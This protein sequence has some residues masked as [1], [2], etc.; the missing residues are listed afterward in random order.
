MLDP[1]IRAVLTSP[2][3]IRRFF[4]TFGGVLI[5]LLVLL[6]LVAGLS[7]GALKSAAVTFLGNFAATMAILIV[8][9]G[10]Y[11]SVTPPGLRNAEVIPLRNVEI[12]E[13]IIDLRAN[14][15]DYWF[16]GR[17]GNHFRTT[18]LPVLDKA[19]RHERRHIRLRIV[20]PDPD[21]DANAH[22][23]MHM[24][25]GLGE[26]ADLDTLSAHV[27]ATIVA[28]ATACS[29]NPY[30]RAD[31]GLCPGVPVLRFDVSTSGA[32][33]TRDA[34]HLPALLANAGNAYFEMF[35]DAVENELAQSRTITWDAGAIAGCDSADPFNDT[36]LT[37]INGL[38]R[39]SQ[40]ILEKARAVLAEAS[41]RYAQR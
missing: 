30:L 15:S 13:Q 35:K 3:T 18:V 2:Y 25:R 9:F 6:F 26:V 24:K 33:I 4:L 31:V 22:L 17:S 8:T 32:L 21:K 19:A 34:T 40:P 10:F 23:Y 1:S 36:V 39:Q 28:I 16:W 12:S 11:V 5:A 27:T 37:S 41:H 14:V 29:G 20:L 7:D 38:P